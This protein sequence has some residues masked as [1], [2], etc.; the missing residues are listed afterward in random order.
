MDYLQRNNY[1]TQLAILFVL[2][3]T[4]LVVVQFIF[5]AIAAVFHISAASLLSGSPGIARVTQSIGAFFTLGLPA[6]VFGW[7]INRGQPT[8]YLR[9]T[10][11][12]SAKQMLLAMLVILAAIVVGGSLAKLTQ[13]MPLPVKWTSWF[14]KLEDNYN[15]DIMLIANLKTTKDFVI[16]LL[17]LALL[18]AIMEEML[19]RGC[20][21]QVLT[22]LTRRPWLG[23]LLTGILFSAVHLSFFGFLPRLFLGMALGYLFYLSNNIW[24]NIWAHFFNNAMALTSVYRLSQAGKLTAQTVN[25]SMNDTF[26]LYLGVL[27]LLA[28]ITLLV[29]FKKESDRVAAPYHTEQEPYNRTNQ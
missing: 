25:D 24:L 6:L 7:V 1:V 19:F 20:L 23:I 26:P 22:G 17:L 27:G 18:P 11:R 3:G 14:K 15:S 9:F 21:Q 12:V 13:V 28:T 5:L 4:G 16:S 10:T 29:L 8:Q 2:F